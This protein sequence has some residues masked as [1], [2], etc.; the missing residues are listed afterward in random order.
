MRVRV[1]S[2]DR[3]NQVILEEGVYIEIMKCLTC[4]KENNHCSSAATICFDIGIEQREWKDFCN[5]EK[6]KKHN[7][8]ELDICFDYVLCIVFV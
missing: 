3:R 1:V 5:N 2:L 7:E 4:L 6:K 8:H